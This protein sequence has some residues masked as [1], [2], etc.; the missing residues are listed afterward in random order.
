MEFNKYIIETEFERTD[1]DMQ[2]SIKNY[3]D[4]LIQSESIPH[5]K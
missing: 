2:A 4:I 1:H 3:K 5:Q